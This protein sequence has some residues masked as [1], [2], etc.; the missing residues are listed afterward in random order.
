MGGCLQSF[1]QAHRLDAAGEGGL[2][3]IVPIR[4]IACTAGILDINETI[5]RLM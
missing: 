2:K 1:P 4:P 3:N 5:I